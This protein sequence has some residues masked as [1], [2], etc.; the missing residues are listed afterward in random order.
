MVEV[1]SGPLINGYGM[2]VAVVMVTL[3]AA[4]VIVAS[5]DAR[6]SH[7]PFHV[8]LSG[9]QFHAFLLRQLLLYTEH[10]S[11]AAGL[12]SA[13]PMPTWRNQSCIVNDVQKGPWAEARR[14]T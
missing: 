13:C 2:E 5:L 8:F 4:M 14:Y 10:G 12:R 1:V 11:T 7:V 9:Q 3:S 6:E